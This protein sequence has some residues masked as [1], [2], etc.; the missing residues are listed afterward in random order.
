MNPVVA[1]RH[2]PASFFPP[3]RPPLA[4]ASDQCSFILICR[5]NVSHMHPR[6]LKVLCTVSPT[7]IQIL[8][9]RVHFCILYIV[10]SP[11]SRVVCQTS[12]AYSLLMRAEKLETASVQGSLACL[13]PPRQYFCNAHAHVYFECGTRTTGQSSVSISHHVIFTL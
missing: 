8:N 10:Y 11:K 9:V 1:S 12:Y 6:M 4:K 5:R 7:A 13:A 3:K 2:L